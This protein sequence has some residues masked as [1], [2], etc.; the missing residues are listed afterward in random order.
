[1]PSTQRI[2]R[3]IDP[4]REVRRPPLVAMNFLHERRCRVSTAEREDKG[5]IG[6]LLGRFVG[7]QQTPPRC[8]IALRVYSP[9]GR[10]AAKVFLGDC[11]HLKAGRPVCPKIDVPHVGEAR[12]LASGA[13]LSDHVVSASISAAQ[14][15]AASSCRTAPSH[16]RSAGKAFGEH[17]P[18]AAVR[19]HDRNVLIEGCCFGWFPHTSEFVS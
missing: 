2:F 1:M 12:L 8:I 15:R 18:S 6:F 7:S 10:P 4:G 19:H 13:S 16:P 14:L 17:R 5:L 9:S 11:V 3:F